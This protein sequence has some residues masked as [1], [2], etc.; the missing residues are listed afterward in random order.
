MVKFSSILVFI[1]GTPYGVYGTEF[2]LG[3]GVK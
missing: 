1:I 2:L 3:V